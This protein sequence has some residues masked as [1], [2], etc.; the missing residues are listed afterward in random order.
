[1]Y[2][3]EMF[4]DTLNGFVKCNDCTKC[5]TCVIDVDFINVELW[6]IYFGFVGEADEG[7]STNY[8]RGS[9]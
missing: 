7:N 3:I 4:D 6:I 5:F 1:M 9:L 2:C 8:S